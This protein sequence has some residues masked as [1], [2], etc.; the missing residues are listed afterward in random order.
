MKVFVINLARRPDRLAAIT[1]DLNDHGISFERID[2]IDA[3]T[4]PILKKFRRPF[5]KFL[6]GKR[7][8]GDGPIANYLSFCKIWQKMIDEHMEQ[9]LIL[10]DD[11]KLLNWDQRF[12]DIDIEQFGL[13]VLRLGA[14]NEAC[15]LE[16]LASI[17]PEKTVLERKL[18]KG[19]IWGNFATIVTLTAA[20]KFLHHKK[21]WFPSDDFQSFEK[22]FGIKYAIVSP[23]VWSSTE[24]VSD[25]ELVKGKLSTAQLLLLKII[26]PLRRRLLFP[27]I[28]AYL[29]FKT[30]LR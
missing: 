6:L 4:S 18:V 14:A 26:K 13:D 25:V 15:F 10:E 17:H 22:C 24:G 7:G 5:F 23:L 27:A 16:K 1:Q 2:A 20:K 11:A 30:S 9:A 12:L 29:R 21:F 8:Y 3:K 19:K 28:H